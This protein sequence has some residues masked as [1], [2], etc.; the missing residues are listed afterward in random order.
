MSWEDSYFLTFWGEVLVFLMDFFIIFRG[1]DESSR[2][3]WLKSFS[4]REEIS[5]YLQ[6]LILMENSSRVMIFILLSSNYYCIYYY[7]Y[8]FFIS[9]LSLNYSFLLTLLTL[10]L[11]ILTWFPVI[12]KFD[13]I[14]STSSSCI[15]W[16][17]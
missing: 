11:C 10:L 14:F 17:Y 16:F 15:Y 12:S 2:F 6:E 1:W 8:W 3:S 9:L 5:F 7:F 13:Y 4:L